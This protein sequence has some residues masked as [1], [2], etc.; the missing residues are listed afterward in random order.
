MSAARGSRWW[1]RILLFLVVAIAAVPL[2][3]NAEWSSLD[4]AARQAAGGSYVELSEG[5][6]HYAVAGPADGQPVLLVHGFSVPYYIWDPTF[7][8]LADAGFRVIRYDLYGRGWSDRPEG[9]YDRAR[10]VRQAAELLDA[11]EVRGAADVVGLSMGGS[12]VAGLAADHPLRVR[13]V[14][15]V[16]PLM[17]PRDVSPLDMPVVGDWLF[18]AWFLPSMPKGQ[19]SDFVDASRFA[20]WSERYR[21]QMRFRGFGRAILSTIRNYFPTDTSRDFRT[22]ASQGRPV[23]LVWG[24]QDQTV[25]FSR[26]EV[27]GAI[28]GKHEFLPVDAAGHLPHLEQPDVVHPRLI[29]FL[30]DPG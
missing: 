20:H 3:R 17:L 1:R 30:H 23:L 10:F 25:P 5:T 26:S 22:L 27:V 7:T 29:G 19:T 9:P 12:I 15:L 13:R 16:D 14:V 4:D 18:R 8:A 24:R 2:A 28:L 11:L 21:P 6:V